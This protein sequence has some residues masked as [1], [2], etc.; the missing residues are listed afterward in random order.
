[1]RAVAAEGEPGDGAGVGVDGLDQ[2]ARVDR[3]EVDVVVC[4]AA[5]YHT[6]SGIIGDG[7]GE[8]RE[9]VDYAHKRAL[10]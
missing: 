2:R 7:H 4:A 8:V 6:P 10:R 3:E 9:T 1:M 5:G